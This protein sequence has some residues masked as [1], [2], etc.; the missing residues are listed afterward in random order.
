MNA[1]LIYLLIYGPPLVLGILYH[2]RQKKK[3]PGNAM[4]MYLM[5]AI[6]MTVSSV[7]WTVFLYMFVIKFMQ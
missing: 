4:K 6:L 2:F 7:L 1:F 5:P 3:F